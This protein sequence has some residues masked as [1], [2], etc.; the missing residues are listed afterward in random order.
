MLNVEMVSAQAQ[1]LKKAMLLEQLN[2]WKLLLSDVKIQLKM[3]PA[4][5]WSL[6]VHLWV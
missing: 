1:R 6:I 3:D 5:V 2:R 4:T